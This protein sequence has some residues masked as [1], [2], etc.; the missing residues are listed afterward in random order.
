MNVVKIDLESPAEVYMVFG[1]EIQEFFQVVAAADT[2]RKS[3]EQGSKTI[4]DQQRTSLEVGTSVP[5]K[6]A[7]FVR[8]LVSKTRLG[9]L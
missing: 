1:C 7:L 9:G 2:K 4:K 5:A 3:N 8:R 6:E